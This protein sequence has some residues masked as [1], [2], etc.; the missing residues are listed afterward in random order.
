MLS[1]DDRGH[2]YWMINSVDGLPVFLA[3]Q[4]APSRQFNSS[5]YSLSVLVGFGASAFVLLALGAIFSRRVIRPLENAGRQLE[6]ITRSGD[7]STRVNDRHGGEIGAFF[8]LINRLLTFIQGQ[9]SSLRDQNRRLEV[10]SH[11][12][13]LTG[14]ANRRHLDAYLERV[15]KDALSDREAVG[16]C[17]IDIDEFKPYNDNYGHQNGDAVLRQV[18]QVLSANLHT[19]TDLLARFGGEE[20]CVVLKGTDLA[21][22]VRVAERLRRGIEGQAIAHDH[23]RVGQVLTVSVGV[24]SAIPSDGQQEPT[25]TVT[26]IR[27]PSERGQG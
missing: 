2:L 25:A 1:R 16:I 15:W 6:T 13:P 5:V 8:G 24:S 18:A 9:E 17:M 19:A 4:D 14:V 10:L 3:R 23:S 22:A 11:E 27:K 21:S 20:F 26:P 7:Y 12:D